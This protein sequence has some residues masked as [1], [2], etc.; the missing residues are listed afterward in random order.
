MPE[1]ITPQE[2]GSEKSVPNQ[3]SGDNHLDI[4]RNVFGHENFRG[5]QQDVVEAISA[6]KDVLAIIPTGGGKS[7]CYWV[8]GLVVS[9]VPDCKVLFLRGE[10]WD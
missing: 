4:L 1:P 10:C 8:P 7:L 3:Q 2:S 9:G 6:N 5:I